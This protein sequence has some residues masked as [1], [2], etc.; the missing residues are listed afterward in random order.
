M[1]G[2]S[3]AKAHL[4]AADR[5]A[6]LIATRHTLEMIVDYDEETRDKKFELHC[7]QYRLQHGQDVFIDRFAARTRS[8]IDDLVVFFF[9]FSKVI[10][11]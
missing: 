2:S 11:H 1:K 10:L 8:A 5:R 7:C 9:L 6:I 3:S 4:F